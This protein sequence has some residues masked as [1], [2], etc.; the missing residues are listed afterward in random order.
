METDVKQ[1]KES[2]YNFFI[3]SH[4]S[5]SCYLVKKY[6]KDETLSNWSGVLIK[7]NKRK[8]QKYPTLITS[9]HLMI[10]IIV[11]KFWTPLCDQN[12]NDTYVTVQLN[13]IIHKISTLNIMGKPQS[14]MCVWLCR[15]SL[16]A[17]NK[18]PEHA[19][20]QSLQH[21]LLRQYGGKS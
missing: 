13:I 4:K 17:L 16:N 7:T 11:L 9:Q 12:I 5:L 6:L 21:H 3:N 2:N 19:G 8:Y 14:S 18:N 15:L 20:L 10:K 1:R